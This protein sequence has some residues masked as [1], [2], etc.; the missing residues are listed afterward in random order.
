MRTP[1]LRLEPRATRVRVIWCKTQ[2]NVTCEVCCSHNQYASPAVAVVATAIPEPTRTNDLGPHN[3]GNVHPFFHPSFR[4]LV[5]PHIS[6]FSCSRKTCVT[7]SA[8]RCR[9]RIP[10]PHHSWVAAT[11]LT[12]VFILTRA[13]TQCVEGGTPNNPM[14]SCVFFESQRFH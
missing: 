5:D 1:N 6:F 7:R 11:V 12:L 8:V 4:A 3:S 10:R 14:L 13:F 9:E 2:K